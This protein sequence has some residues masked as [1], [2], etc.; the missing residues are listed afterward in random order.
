MAAVT[1]DAGVVKFGTVDSEATVANVT[2][3]SIDIS[4]DTV[5]TTSMGATAYK[6]FLGGK[7]SWTGSCEVHW[8]NADDAGMEAFETALLA[9]DLAKQVMLYPGGASVDY[10]KGTIAVTGVSMSGSI[11]DTVKLSVNFTGS[12][13]LTHTG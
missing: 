2:G 11:G 12:G 1:G 13:V 8:D 5:E 9:N 4:M 7:Y 3:W 10:W 6:T